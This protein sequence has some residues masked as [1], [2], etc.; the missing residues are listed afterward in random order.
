MNKQLFLLGTILVGSKAAIENCPTGAGFAQCNSATSALYSMT[1]SEFGALTQEEQVDPYGDALNTGFTTCKLPGKYYITDCNNDCPHIQDALDTTEFFRPMCNDGAWSMFELFDASNPNA[2]QFCDDGYYLLEQDNFANDGLSSNYYTGEAGTD[3]VMDTHV[4]VEYTKCNAG[5]GRVNGNFVTDA[6]CQDCDSTN[7]DITKRTFQP[8]DNS[9]DAC[10]FVT[11]CTGSQYIVDGGHATASKD[12]QCADIRTECDSDGE[13]ISTPAVA[14]VSDIVCGT[15]RTECDSDGEYI[16]TPAEAKVSDIVCGTSRLECDEA[17][18]YI[19][20]PAEAKVS[21]IVCAARRTECDDVDGAEYYISNQ[22]TEA[23]TDVTCSPKKTSCDPGK[24]LVNAADD[25]AVDNACHACPILDDNMLQ[26]RGCLPIDAE[27]CGGDP[28]SIRCEL[29]VD[30]LLWNTASIPS[31]FDADDAGKF[32]FSNFACR[33][34]YYVD[35][36]SC[37]QCVDS[38]VPG[39][40][41]ICTDDSGSTGAA[42]S[43]NFLAP[44]YVVACYESGA[45]CDS[46]ETTAG[47]KCRA[48]TQ[49]TADHYISAK[50]ELGLRDRT[51]TPL[52][53]CTDLQF[54]KEEPQLNVERSLAT[55]KWFNVEDDRLCDTIRTECGDGEYISVA[56]VAGDSDIECATIRIQCPDHQYISTAAVDRKSDIVCADIR[57]ECTGVGEYISVEA[58]AG[59]SDIVCASDAVCPEGTYVTERT[60]AN[61]GVCNGVCADDVPLHSRTLVKNCALNSDESGAY[62]TECKANFKRDREDGDDDTRCIFNLDI[63]HSLPGDNAGCHF[64]PLSNLFAYDITFENEPGHVTN[65]APLDVSDFYTTA[66]YLGKTTASFKLS[67]YDRSPPAAGTSTSYDYKS[68]GVGGCTAA[69]NQASNKI[70]S[71]CYFKAAHES[72]SDNLN[73]AKNDAIISLTTGCDTDNSYLIDPFLYSTGGGANGWDKLATGAFGGQPTATFEFSGDSLATSTTIGVASKCGTDASAVVKNVFAWTELSSTLQDTSSLKLS[74]KAPVASTTEGAYGTDDIQI[75]LGNFD[76]THNTQLHDLLYVSGMY[77]SQAQSQS[78]AAGTVQFDRQLEIPSGFPIS[79]KVTAAGYLRGS[80]E[81]TLTV[82]SPDSEYQCFENGANPNV[83]RNDNTYLTENHLNQ[84]SQDSDCGVSLVVA[85]EADG[86]ITYTDSRYCDTDIDADA[87]ADEDAQAA[88]ITIPGLSLSLSYESVIVEGIRL[89]NTRNYPKGHSTADGG[90]FTTKDFGD[91]T[92][93]FTCD[94]PTCPNDPYMV[95]AKNSAGVFAHACT[96]NGEASTTTNGATN[97]GGDTYDADCADTGEVSGD[98]DGVTIKLPGKVFP[99]FYV[100]GITSFS[101]S[102]TSTV[103]ANPVANPARRLG[104]RLGAPDTQGEIE[105]KTVFTLAPSH[106][107]KH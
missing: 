12:F 26:N 45:N 43:K 2:N 50:G 79:G 59:V 84:D 57:T 48:F 100:Y 49:C 40:L 20:T 25:P 92:G 74:L 28:F 85:C 39:A 103:V 64:E 17:T 96:W 18:E 21:D 66:Y 71:W 105:T 22:G 77:K 99:Q 51:C 1:T 82:T 67:N 53:Q 35:G 7:S 33:L 41:N 58:V 9:P 72:L 11:P 52:T 38:D 89:R 31:T 30:G 56:A 76:I 14:G 75:A 106:I 98:I 5:Q 102:D 73:T 62:V 8:N 78:S 93:R 63:S 87:C 60:G 81:T 16:S 24:F 42:C 19:S 104:A 44:E 91:E 61:A 68:C 29:T 32:E 94:N 95:L 70:Q 107:I 13:Y 3:G 101:S 23:L 54:E 37:S 10:Q 86:S 69:I 65:T 46:G 4:C 27:S 47:F 97:A 36:E 83:E 55:W 80:C 15:I 34:G 88:L 90:S 6:Y